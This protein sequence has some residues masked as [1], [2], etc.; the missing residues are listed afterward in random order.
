MFIPGETIAQTFELPYAKEEI[1][2]VIIS[3]RQKDRIVLEKIITAQKNMKST[4]NGK[5]IVSSYI[6]EAESLLFEDNCEY[7]IQINVLFRSG[8]TSGRSTSLEIAGWT[9]Y[10]HIRDIGSSA[11]Q[12]SF[13][14]LFINDDGKLIWSHNPD[15]YEF[16]IDHDDGLLVIQRKVV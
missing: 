16:A 14:T 8:T 10:Q 4:D 5:T 9:G 15:A 3:Y 11:I 12:K 1:G 7:R 13:G 2:Q 6:S